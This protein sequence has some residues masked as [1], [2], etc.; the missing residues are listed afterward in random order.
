LKYVVDNTGVTKF[1]ILKDAKALASDLSTIEYTIDSGDKKITKVNTEKAKKKEIVDAVATKIKD[2]ETKFSGKTD[3]KSKKQKEVETTIVTEKA[4]ENDSI[5]IA[6]SDVKFELPISYD[7]AGKNIVQNTFTV[8]PDGKKYTIY[9]DQDYLKDPKREFPFTIDPRLI[10]GFF[11]EKDAWYDSYYPTSNRGSNNAFHI[12]VGGNP[13]IN[14]GGSGCAYMGTSRSAIKFTIPNEVQEAG[15][16]VSANYRL[17]QYSSTGGG[18]RMRVRNA[19]DFDEW[20]V[21]WNN[22]PCI[23]GDYGFMDV[24]TTNTGCQGC[25][26]E[27]WSSDISQLLRDNLNGGER[28]FKVVL[29]DDWEGSTRGA[30]FCAKDGNIGGH[31][32]NFWDKGPYLQINLNPRPT[33]PNADTPDNGD[34]VKN[35]DLSVAVPDLNNCARTNPVV[36]GISQIN[37]DGA[38]APCDSALTYSR[39]VQK[40][41]LSIANSW[42]WYEA[43]SAIKLNCGNGQQTPGLQTLN[44]RYDWAAIN[45]DNYGLESGWSNTRNFTLDSSTPVRVNDT[46]LPAFSKGNTNVTL[47]EYGD[48]LLTKYTIS[49]PEYDGAPS[50]ISPKNQPQKVL[51]ATGRNT[52]NFDI[53]SGVIV[54][55]KDNSAVQPNQTWMLL[56]WDIRQGSLNGKCLDALVPSLFGST[57]ENTKLG[58]CGGATSS[59]WLLDEKGRL[60]SRTV[61]RCLEL[62]DWNSQNTVNVA[63]ENTTWQNSGAVLP[64]P[65]TDN[66]PKVGNFYPESA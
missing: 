43:S 13:C 14:V 1:F 33:S 46:K 4:D 5:T 54:G 29:H 18:F 26:D 8:S 49:R 58:I 6:N 11:T 28:A 59:Q 31:P 17:R 61:D 19:C 65:C 16:I 55:N 12:V 51:Q 47:P 34:F 10:G 25:G 63:E 22:Q 40:S 41:G 37:D 56:G 50:Y 23:A 45:R 60:K 7:N 38:A 64:K 3:D 62:V 52:N 53:G 32:C 36:Y 66:E 15:N 44:G 21:T 27:R 39:I 42:P 35:C 48:N 20:N 9:P 30:A 57:S 24:G 2:I